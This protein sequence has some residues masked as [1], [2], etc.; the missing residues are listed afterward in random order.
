MTAPAVSLET[1]REMLALYIEAEQTVLKNQSYTIKDR[2][3]T[4]A[5]LAII[6]RER[7][8][9]Q[10]MVDGLSGH[11]IRSRRAVPRDR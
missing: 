2:T 10:Q 9:W 11:G 7:A 5:N 1:A 3:F 6:T 8:K 4:R